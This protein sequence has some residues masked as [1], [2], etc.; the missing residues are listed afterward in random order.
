MT[1]FIKKIGIGTAQWGMDCSVSNSYGQTTLDEAS[2]ILKLAKAS[3]IK[4]IDTACLY[5]SAEFVLS[6]N[7]LTSFRLSQDSTL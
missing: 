4:I 2:K 7:D 5:G 1:S 6:K 3:Q